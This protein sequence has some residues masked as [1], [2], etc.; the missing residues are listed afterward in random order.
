MDYNSLRKSNRVAPQNSKPETFNKA[1]KNRSNIFRRM[2]E[3]KAFTLMEL[4]VAIGIFAVIVGREHIERVITAVVE[5][6][7]QRLVS[8]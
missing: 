1:L 4:M 6:T 3:T 8:T 5:N 7:N 2:G